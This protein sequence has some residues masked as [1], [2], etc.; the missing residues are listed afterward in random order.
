MGHYEDIQIDRREGWKYQST[1]GTNGDDY[2]AR[3]YVGDDG[4]ITEDSYSLQYRKKLKEEKEKKEVTASSSSSSSRSSSNS[5]SSNSDDNG[6]CV[7]FIF[8]IIPVLPI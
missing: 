4:K 8:T 1:H 6:S 7:K 3:V 2:Y 5:S